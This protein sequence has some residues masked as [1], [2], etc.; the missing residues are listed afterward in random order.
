VR[1]AI[2]AHPDAP[3]GARAAALFALVEM[4]WPAG[5][6]D[7]ARVL[8]EEGLRLAKE[9]NDTWYVTLSLRNLAIIAMLRG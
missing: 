2:P 4:I 9:A 1:G 3:P 6:A 5:E 7:R 8:T